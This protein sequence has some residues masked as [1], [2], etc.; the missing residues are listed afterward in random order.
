MTCMNKVNDRYDI[1][2]VHMTKK[3][4]KTKQTKTKQN[5]QKNKK[6][7]ALVLCFFNFTMHSPIGLLRCSDENNRRTH[8]L[9]F[10]TCTKIKS[11]SV[12]N[13]Y[14]IIPKTIQFL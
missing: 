10:V 12:I 8:A 6:T 4:T 2:D 11:Y 5:K 3:K 9:I 13:L 1:V 7:D 14:S